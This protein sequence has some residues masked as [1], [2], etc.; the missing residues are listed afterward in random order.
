MRPSGTTAAGAKGTKPPDC[1]GKTMPPGTKP[2]GGTKPPDC[3]GQLY[4]KAR[5]QR[6]KKRA[7]AAR[8]ETLQKRGL[9]A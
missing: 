2:P 8:T 6:G 9:R 1:A 4:L 5:S 3:E 7:E